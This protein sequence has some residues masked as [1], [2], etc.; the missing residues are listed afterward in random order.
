MLHIA[1]G[2]TIDDR[3]IEE[4]F[5]RASGP[6]GQNVNKVATAVELRFDVRRSSLPDE[7][8][9]RLARLAGRRMTEAGVLLIDSRVHRS[10]AD[11]RED[12]RARLKDLLRRAAVIPKRRRPTKPRPAA[13]ERRLAAKKRTAALKANRSGGGRSGEDA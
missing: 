6:G 12:A 11:N 9:D 3:E 10:Q 13:R 7:V 1:D 5:V 4:R 8:K 2:I